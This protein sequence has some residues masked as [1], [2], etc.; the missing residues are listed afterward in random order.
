M[1]ITKILW[2]IVFILILFLFLKPKKQEEILADGFYEN[3]YMIS[4][5]E[6]QMKVLVDGETVLLGCAVENE[7]ESKD[8]IIDIQV[9]KNRVVKITWKEGLVE[10]RVEAVSLT[11]GWMNLSTYGK[12]NISPKGELYI[13]T[14]EEVHLLS[15]AGTLLNQEKVSF[16]ILN[17]EICAVIV[18]GEKDMQ[19]IRVLIHGEEDRIFHE[20][21]KVTA[22]DE[23]IVT[24]DGTETRHPA[25]EEITFTK[26]MGAAKIRCEDG[27]I[28]L[29]SS[30]RASGCPE[31]R[32]DI[33]VS[34]YEEGFVVRNELKLEEY[35]YSVVSSEMPSSYP[36]E[37]LKVQAVCARTYALYQMDQ[38]YYSEYGAH[39]DDTVN[40]QVYNNVAE[41]ESTKKAVDETVGQYISYQQEPIC[42]YFYS[43]SC[44]I[45]SEVKDVWISSG[46]S[47]G[48]LAGGF[49]GI[50]KED[51]D[52]IEADYSSEE[53]F[54]KFIM[55]VTENAFEKEEPWFRWNG[56]I[57]YTSL[58]EHVEKHRTGWLKENPS[59]YKLEAGSDSL[60]KIIK[61]QV[62]DRSKGGVIKKICLTGEEGILTVTGEYQIRKVLCPAG[63]VLERKDGSKT[64]CNMLPS[65]YFSVENKEEILISGGGYGHGVGMS[66]NGAKAMAE[67]SYSY[68]KILEFYYPGTEL[69][70]M[71]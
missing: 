15:K 60:G 12:K 46:T 1:K 3:C 7:S 34:S 32:G 44:G 2:F 49:Q 42:A 18:T 10:D 30:K 38:A 61:V 31:Y 21:V 14:G 69:L 35:L 11:E 65:G 67:Q 36:D 9:E 27:K 37:A 50:K 33:L 66:Q 58:T 70:E 26:D 52:Q 71:Y 28:K 16:Y 45:T 23:F 6:N 47:P 39:V 55:S 56:G 63:T 4:L 24:I 17:D 57:S 54:A 5:K 29:L 20:N 53:K 43:T 25:L 41:T 40:S 62:T 48:Y 64:T 51:E 59:S 22:T 13:K 8:K 19:K 68:E